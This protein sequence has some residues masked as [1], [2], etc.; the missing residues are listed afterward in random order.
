M[1]VEEGNAYFCL[2]L[3]EFAEVTFT[4]R[5]KEHYISKLRWGGSIRKYEQRSYYEQRYAGS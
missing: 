3:E 4:F 2:D 1:K 5:K